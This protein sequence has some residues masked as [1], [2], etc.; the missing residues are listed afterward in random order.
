MAQQIAHSRGHA[1]DIESFLPPSQRDEYI[2]I[3]SGEA[4][5]AEGSEDSDTPAEGEGSEAGESPSS[6]GVGLPD[7]S[8]RPGKR[9]RTS[10]SLAQMYWRQRIDR[11]LAGKDWRSGSRASTPRA[12]VKPDP[13]AP[14]PAPAPSTPAREPKAKDVIT[15]ADRTDIQASASYW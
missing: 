3:V 15:A 9:Q 13:D 6:A 5:P 2:A 1:F 12:S 8:P 11:G 7:G 10:S 14:S 4:T